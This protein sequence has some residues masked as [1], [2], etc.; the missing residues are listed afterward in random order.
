MTKVSNL[1]DKGFDDLF[2]VMHGKIEQMAEATNKLRPLSQFEQLAIRL[3]RGYKGRSIHSARE[4]VLIELEHVRRAYNRLNRENLDLYT[5]ASI[6]SGMDVM[7]YL[8]FK[9]VTFD[10]LEHYRK[11]ANYR[12]NKKVK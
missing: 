5:F 12:N 7:N 1:K 11:S 10:R 9:I 3:T 2:K 8:D 4:I 6:Q